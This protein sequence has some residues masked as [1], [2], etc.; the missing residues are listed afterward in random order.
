VHGTVPGMGGIDEL[1]TTGISFVAELDQGEIREFEVAPEDVDLPRADIA[2]LKGGDPAHNAQAIRN[3]LAGA[4]GPYRN[5]VLLNAAGALVVAGKAASLE[6]GVAFAAESI[7][8][9][10]ATKVLERLVQQTNNQVPA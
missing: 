1:T 2:D 10:A 6:D 9:G 3:L 5:I 7:D 8:S 4:P